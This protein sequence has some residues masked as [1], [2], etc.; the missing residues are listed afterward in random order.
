MKLLVQG[1]SKMDRQFI[2]E[3]RNKLLQMKQELIQNLIQENEEVLEIFASQKNPKD[4]AELASDDSDINILNRIGTH[5]K[6]KLELIESALTRIQNGKYGKC[7][8]TGKQIS[9][10]RLRAIPYALYCIEVQEEMDRRGR[11]K[12]L[13]YSLP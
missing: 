7:L 4:I 13:Q 2:E 5:D 8:K 10:E 3:M 12:H 6:Q 1:E 11:K 9:P